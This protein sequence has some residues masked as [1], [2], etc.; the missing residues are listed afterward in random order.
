MDQDRFKLNFAVSPQPTDTTCGPSCLQAVYDF[1]GTSKSVEDLVG[2]I[3]ELKD[4]GTLAVNLGI[5]AL[6]HGYKAVLYTYNLRI[7]DPTWFGRK[8]D[9]KPLLREQLAAKPGA[10]RRTAI[11]SYIKFL[12]LGGDVRF[13]DLTGSLI[14]KQLRKGLPIIVG[15]SSTFLYR[16]C[17]EHPVTNEDDSIHGKPAGH[18]VVLYGYDRLKKRVW[19]A[20]PYPGHPY[21]DEMFYPVEM[22]RLINSIL[23]G[24]LTY[25]ANLL[26]IQPAT[27]AHA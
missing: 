13:A 16:A 17:R 5:D 3:P 10:K 23:L 15:L 24:V 18:F 2:S 19:V 7:F 8:A 14:R 9:L 21:G 12:E 11:K 22:A 4:G 27:K 6:K 1:H 25:D 26:V 20:D